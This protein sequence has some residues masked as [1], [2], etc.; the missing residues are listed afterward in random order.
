M[1]TSLIPPPESEYI[2]LDDESEAERVNSPEERTYLTD[3]DIKM[4]SLDDFGK[5]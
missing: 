3:A 2:P 1:Q 5:F 4:Y